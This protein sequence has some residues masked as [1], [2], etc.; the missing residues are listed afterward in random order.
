MLLGP[1]C[2]G[3]E[4]HI[5]SS[6][7]PTWGISA[8]ETFSTFGVMFFLFGLG[9]KM[10]PTMMLCPDRKSAII[11]VLMLFP[12]LFLTIVVSLSLTINIPMDTTLAK[13]LAY[14]GGAQALTGF[15]VV[16]YLVTEL[17][18]L[19]T[20]L[21]RLAISSSMFCDTINI[22]LSIIGTSLGEVE[23]GT[24]ASAGPVLLSAI[25]LILALVFLI[26]PA[27]LWIINKTPPGKPMAEINLMFVYVIVLLSGFVSECIGQHYILGPMFLGLL[28]PNGPPLGTAIENKADALVSGLLYPT[29]VSING[30]QTDVF[31]I[32]FDSFWTIGVVVLVAFL[33]KFVA[34]LSGSLYVELTYREAIVLALIVNAKGLME[35]VIFSIYRNSEVRDY[36]FDEKV[37]SNGLISCKPR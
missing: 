35:L 15:P 26:K 34:V 28:V 23:H 31:G 29:F 5:G 37:F 30:L 36:S 12:T 21:G 14:I 27:V 1:S 6:I 19:N 20:D 2:L 22:F 8:I 24:A 9:V 16:S 13:S 11:A 33:V 25:A 10:D 4:G 32:G 3:R 18:I 17:R 7:F